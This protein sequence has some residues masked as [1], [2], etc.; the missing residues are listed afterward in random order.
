MKHKAITNALVL[1]IL[2]LCTSVQTLTAAPSTIDRS[3]K[4]GQFRVRIQSSIEPVVINRIHHWIVYLEDAEGN[5]VTGAAITVSGSMPAHD[6]GL[7]TQPAARA[8]K[9]EGEYLVE[10]LRFHMP[11]E[12]QMTMDISA[13]GTSDRLLIPLAL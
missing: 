9:R 2:L 8:G 4:D 13:G 3:S 11:G 6:H 1:L 12:W 10:G 7:P 5:P